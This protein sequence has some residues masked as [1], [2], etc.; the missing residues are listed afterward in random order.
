MGCCCCCCCWLQV[1]GADVE[2]NLQG[3]TVTVGAANGLYAGNV[4]EV[5]VFVTDS[6]GAVSDAETTLTG[7]QLMSCVGVWKGWRGCGAG[8]G[9]WVRMKRFPPPSCLV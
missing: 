7:E 5:E 6:F 4:Y 3:A 9:G 2:L 1:S 8:I